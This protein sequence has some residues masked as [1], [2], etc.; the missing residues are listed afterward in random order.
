MFLLFNR[1]SE[2]SHCLSASKPKQ[3]ST[4]K[5]KWPGTTDY[6]P[7]STPKTQLTLRFKILL[8][9][10]FFILLELLGSSGSDIQIANAIRLDSEPPSERHNFEGE[11]RS[12]ALRDHGKTVS[13]SFRRA[14]WVTCRESSSVEQISRTSNNIL[15]PVHPDSSNADDCNNNEQSASQS[16]KEIRRQVPPT[17]DRIWL[18][19]FVSRDPILAPISFSDWRNKGLEPFKKNMLAE[20]ERNFKTSLKAEHWDIRPVEEIMEAVPIGVDSVQ[21]CQLVSKWS[22]PQ[23]KVS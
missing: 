9:L 21:W 23:D 11:S 15:T 18:I 4:G 12:A 2:V 5:V 6:N 3:G 20:V 1:F 16:S 10:H 22:Q 13:G 17:D 8:V 19:G 14:K 7:N